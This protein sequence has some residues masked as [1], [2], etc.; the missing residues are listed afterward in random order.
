MANIVPWTQWKP[1][2]FFPWVEWRAVAGELE[3]MP[4]VPIDSGTVWTE[5]R[6]RMSR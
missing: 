5:R 6:W 3:T 2:R 1:Y 4:G